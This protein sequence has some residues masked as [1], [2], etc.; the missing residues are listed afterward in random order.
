MVEAAAGYRNFVCEDSMDHQLSVEPE[1]E[2]P[3]IFENGNHLDSIFNDDLG[4]AAVE[5]DDDGSSEVML[6]ASSA[7]EEANSSGPEEEVF[8]DDTSLDNHPDT[9]E[10]NA[11]NRSISSFEPACEDDISIGSTN[12]PDIYGQSVGVASLHSVSRLMGDEDDTMKKSDQ[13]DS[14]SPSERDNACKTDEF[15]QDTSLVQNEI[16]FK[17]SVAETP[18]LLPY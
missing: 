3:D 18:G 5:A 13:T 15:L 4:N 9:N 7:H 17:S 6:S 14:N 16:H 10:P 8:G 2:Y 1:S 12:P 11:D